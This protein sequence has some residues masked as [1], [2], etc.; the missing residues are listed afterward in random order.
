MPND[1][2]RKTQAIAK[3]RNFH[4]LVFNHRLGF[5]RVVQNVHDP[6]WHVSRLARLE[7]KANALQAKELA[8]RRDAALLFENDADTILSIELPY[9]LLNFCPWLLTYIVRR[10]R[11]KPFYN[12]FN[13]RT[14][15]IMRCCAHLRLVP[16]GW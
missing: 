16:C 5:D 14:K 10:D 8:C 9:T 4:R 13:V 6:H 7:H 3:A 12:T 11:G 2:V 15:F 1:T